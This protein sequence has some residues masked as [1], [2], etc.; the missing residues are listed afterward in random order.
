MQGVGEVE[1]P[2]YEEIGSK[3]IRSWA[4]TMPDFHD[5]GEYAFAFS[6]PPYPLSGRRAEVQRLFRESTCIILPPSEKVDI[7]DWSGSDLT[8]VDSYFEAGMEWWGVFLF[9]VFQPSHSR[10][11]VISGSTTD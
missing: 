10:L 6:Q 1:N 7:F 4:N 8:K 2:R 5:A 3:R 9:T 11:I